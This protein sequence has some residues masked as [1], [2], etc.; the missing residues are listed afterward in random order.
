MNEDT[1]ILFSIAI[2]K[3]NKTSHLTPDPP[4]VPVVMTALTLTRSQSHAPVRRR[5]T[6]IRVMSFG[7]HVIRVS[8]NI[9]TNIGKG[10]DAA[11]ILLGE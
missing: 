2:K 7:S 10:G 8:P 3:P 4:A 5:R 9:Q 6:V 11:E 1:Q